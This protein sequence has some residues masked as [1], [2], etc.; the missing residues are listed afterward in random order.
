MPNED[1]IQVLHFPSVDPSELS[2]LRG[3]LTAVA[4]DVELRERQPGYQAN[5]DWALPAAVVVLVSYPFL[6]GFLSRLGGKSADAV[7]VEISKLYRRLT[8][9]VKWRSAKGRERSG[10]VISVELDNALPDQE[11]E[12]A[13]TFPADMTPTE[14]RN[15]LSRLRSVV[16]RERKA[17]RRYFQPPGTYLGYVA[18]KVTF[19]YQLPEGRWRRM[20][21]YWTDWEEHEQGL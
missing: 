21:P 18:R 6:T 13:F 14:F 4:S 20:W 3:A 10:P 8:G 11:A 7:T 12:I 15:A 1:S 9:R 16:S 5:L 19:Y 2:D 17:A